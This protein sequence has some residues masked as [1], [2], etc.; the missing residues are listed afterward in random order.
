MSVVRHEAPVVELGKDELDAWRGLPAAIV[1]DELNRS[2][3]MDSGIRPIG[4]IDNII[5]GPALTVK[6]MVGDNLAIHHAISEAPSGVFLVIDAGG[7]GPNAVWGGI[8]HQA[9]ELR[10]I[11]GVIVDG[12]VRDAADIRSSRLPCYARGIVPAGPHK[13]WGGEINGTIT[14]GGCAVHAG[15]L[16]V[17]DADGIAVVPAAARSTVR[18]GAERRLAYEQEIIKR[19]RAGETTVQIMDL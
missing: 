9:A 8:L 1:S 18:A 13:G 5:V 3:T 15:D 19:L 6:A 12:C 17:A 4:T 16:V 14:A 7:T 2:G 11:V 10:G